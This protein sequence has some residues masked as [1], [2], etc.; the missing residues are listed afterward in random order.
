MNENAKIAS[1]SRRIEWLEV[2]Q[3]FSMLL[4]V[5][6]HI[7]LSNV[8]FDPDHPLA[9]AM[10][11][12]IY[13]FHMPLFI[14]I[15]GWLFQLTC[16]G[17]DRGYGAVMRRKLSRLGVPFLVFT[18][19]TI[20]L[21]LLLPDL[22]HRRVDAE[23]LF[24]TFILFSSN[25]LGEMWFLITLM[26]LM[27]LFP[28]YRWLDRHS[29]LLW[30]LCVAVPLAVF[31]PE[32]IAE[33]QLSRVMSMLPYFLAG[34]ICCRYGVIERYAS[35]RYVFIAFGA[36]FI[37][38]NV[39]DFYPGFIHR[40]LASTLSSFFGIALSVSV[41]AFITRL[42]PAS[43][44]SFRRYTFQIFLLG[45]FFQMAVRYLYGAVGHLSPLL[46]PGL[47]VGSVLA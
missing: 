21:K 17:A 16:L 43:F 4:V 37:L 30:G 22:M 15:S 42:N 23:E 29:S 44:S 5:L 1:G 45:I 26:V 11:R 6:G 9:A 27:A 24:N 32:D 35:S 14:F 28:V 46:Y 36:L 39:L 20:G 8:P 40:R 34:V 12:I 2:L 25:P 18:A 33:F 13:S 10:E 7:S 47:F 31:F 41:C 3:G 19:V 38:F